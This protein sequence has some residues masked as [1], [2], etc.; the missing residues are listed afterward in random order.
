MSDVACGKLRQSK[1]SRINKREISFKY[2]I[3]K[4]F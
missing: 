1:I 3:V 2:D 4:I